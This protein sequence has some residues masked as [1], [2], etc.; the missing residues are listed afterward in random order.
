MGSF[1]FRA[2]GKIYFSD[3]LLVTNPDSSYTTRYILE[4][5]SEVYTQTPAPVPVFLEKI[6]IPVPPKREGATRFAG[7]SQKKSGC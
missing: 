5:A 1:R 3:R 6:F 7:I 4:P 2:P